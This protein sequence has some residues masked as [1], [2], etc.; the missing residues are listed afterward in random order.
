MFACLLV[1]PQRRWWQLRQS[2]QLAVTDCADSLTTHE[3][4]MNACVC[5][6][7]AS[8]VSVKWSPLKRSINWPLFRLCH[9]NVSPVYMPSSHW[10]CTF[11]RPRHSSWAN[12]TSRRPLSGGMFFS[13]ARYICWHCFHSTPFFTFAGPPSSTYT[14]PHSLLISSAS[15]QVRLCILFV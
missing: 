10:Q 14:G 3:Q 13:W 5:V 1:G 4:S 6:S 11:Q 15:L 2:P 12:F 9:L 8:I 7:I